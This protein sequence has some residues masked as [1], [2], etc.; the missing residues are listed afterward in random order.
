[1]TLD[2]LLSVPFG[3]SMPQ[4]GETG[5]HEDHSP[6]FKSLKSLCLSAGQ[7]VKIVKTVQV[8]QI[9]EVVNGKR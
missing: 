4:Q 3:L 7:I 2:A 6:L 5:N 8:V 1:L 9:V